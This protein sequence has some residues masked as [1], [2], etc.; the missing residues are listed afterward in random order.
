MS[1]YRTTF[2]RNTFQKTIRKEATTPL[3]RSTSRFSTYTTCRAESDASIRQGKSK[4]PTVLQEVWDNIQKY[5]ECVILTK[6]GGFYELYFDQ[7]KEKKTIGNV[8]PMVS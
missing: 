2:L 4:Y 7:A 6:V 5:P 3:W 8:V 1:L